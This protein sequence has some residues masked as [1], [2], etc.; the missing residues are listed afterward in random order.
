MLGKAKKRDRIKNGRRTSFCK[1]AR[2]AR[3]RRAERK[4]RS[5][6]TGRHFVSPAKWLPK[7]QKVLSWSI[8]TTTLE[9]I[10]SKIPNKNQCPPPK[11]RRAGK[12]RRLAG[13]KFPPLEPLHF[14]PAH[15]EF[16]IIFTRIS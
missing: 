11:G 10:L 3:A 4:S 12:T 8:F 1:T 15:R 7:S 14:L 2:R 5:K 6:I 9:L 13:K 16:F